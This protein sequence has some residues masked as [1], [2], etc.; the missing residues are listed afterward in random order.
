MV[1]GNVPALTP[2]AHPWLG[3]VSTIACAVSTK[4]VLQRGNISVHWHRYM[5][6]HQGHGF[7]SIWANGDQ[8]MALLL[9]VEIAIGNPPQCD[10]AICR[11]LLVVTCT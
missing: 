10:S 11:L 6:R 5:S 7:D 2:L 8:L 4:K 3:A 1:Q 9:L